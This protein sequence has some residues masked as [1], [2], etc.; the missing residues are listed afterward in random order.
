MTAVIALSP[1]DTTVVTQGLAYAA[2]GWPVFPVNARTKRPLITDWPNQATTDPEV[3]RA[4]W[5]RNPRAGI[6]I[7]TGSKSGLVVVDLDVKNAKDGP[8]NWDRYLQSKDVYLPETVTVRTRSGGQH[9]YYRVPEGAD[10]TNSAGTVAEG[11]DV[12]GTGGYVVAPPTP[13]YEFITELDGAMLPELPVGVLPEKRMPATAQPR[14]KRS[15]EYAFAAFS[16]G[17]DDLAAAAEGE[18][19]DTLNRVAYSAAQSV[20]DGLLDEATVRGLLRVRGLEAGLSESEVRSTMDSAFSKFEGQLE[21]A[22]V[23]LLSGPW[24]GPY[25]SFDDV[26]AESQAKIPTIW[27]PPESPLWSKGESLMLAGD[28]GVGK[29]TLAEELVVARLG[30]L[31]TVLGYPVETDGGRV[32][33]IAADR[34]KQILRGLNRT[35]GGGV[36][37]VGNMLVFRAGPLPVGIDLGDP[38]C[39]EWL[40]EQARAMGATTVVVDSIKDTFREQSDEGSAGAYNI[41]RQR[42]VSNGVELIEIHHTR[43]TSTQGHGDR[44][45]LDAVYGSRWLTAGAGSVLTLVHAKPAG[46]HED[47]TEESS[48]VLLRQVK[49]ITEPH[50]KMRLTLDRDA[51]R[52]VPASEP[53][54]LSSGILS[55]LFLGGAPMTVTAVCEHLFPEGATPAEVARVRRAL[56]RL[57]EQGKV[58][59]AGRGLY[60]M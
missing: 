7:V 49:A 41:A 34:P 18:R 30:K 29:S 43:K 14:N 52:L 51:G 47:S 42:V 2:R 56:Q 38:A 23:S 6:G 36:D 54:S 10:Y 40:L 45:G 9:R 17:L 15:R 1:N 37:G 53:E 32:L 39:T 5:G 25:Q 44:S 58:K 31:D 26:L 33:Y 19:N 16:G 24:G 57:A 28:V 22:P 35:I 59:R 60:V 27:G 48:P 13:G 20:A 55:A 12:R 3:I 4:I 11:V 21:L 50:D 8:G 46:D